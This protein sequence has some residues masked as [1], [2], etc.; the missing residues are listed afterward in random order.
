MF[1]PEVTLKPIMVRTRGN[2]YIFLLT[3]ALGSIKTKYVFRPWTLNSLSLDQI[4]DRY[5]I[6]DIPNTFYPYVA[7]SRLNRLIFKGETINSY[8]PGPEVQRLY[9]DTGQS[10]EFF[11]KT[12]NGYL[13]IDDQPVTHTTSSVYEFLLDS[14]I[15]PLI[16]LQEINNDIRLY[17]YDGMTGRRQY[18]IKL[19]TAILTKSFKSKTSCHHWVIP[20]L[21]DNQLKS[22]TLNK[23]IVGILNSLPQRDMY[24]SIPLY[25]SYIPP[26]CQQITMSEYHSLKDVVRIDTEQPGMTRGLYILTLTGKYFIPQ[27]I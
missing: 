10:F 1:E 9:L 17:L 13:S 20:K 27:R 3:D 12:A 26:D 11:Y 18:F 23:R 2:Q 5:Q 19:P 22:W 16:V 4:V 7:V 24:F 15:Y 14:N 21:E 25:L 6:I 8:I